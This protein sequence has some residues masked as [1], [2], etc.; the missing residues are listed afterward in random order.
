MIEAPEVRGSC[1]TALCENSKDV[2]SR[3]SY[4]MLR[5]FEVT[6]FLLRLGV[7]NTQTDRADIV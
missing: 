4:P 7:S 3:C 5:Y 1:L 2:A 6:V